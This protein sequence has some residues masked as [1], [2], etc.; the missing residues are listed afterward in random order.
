MR[1]RWCLLLLSALLPH[2]AE[3][4]LN[5]GGKIT[6]IINHFSTDD[7]GAGWKA[8]HFY[9]RWNSTL[10]N[11]R[12][13]PGVPLPSSQTKLIGSNQGEIE[14]SPMARRCHR[15]VMN[16]NSPGSHSILL[17][18]TFSCTLYLFSSLFR[19]N[20]FLISQATKQENQ[21]WELLPFCKL[22][23]YK[24][25][26]SKRTQFT[27]F[28]HMSLTLGSWNL[29]QLFGTWTLSTSKWPRVKHQSS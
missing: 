2:S 21:F 25:P 19:N 10:S 7:V 26:K 23:L 4:S 17:L 20:G 14:H 12:N 27:Q 3:I 24:N 11:T 1:E 18:C 28:P 5:L 22:N 13:L 9:Q 29:D 6:S 8:S 16:L 15:G